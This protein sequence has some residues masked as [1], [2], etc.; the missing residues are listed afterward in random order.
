MA[1]VSSFAPRALCSSLGSRWMSPRSCGEFR[2]EGRGAG[3]EWGGDGVGM[4]FCLVLVRFWLVGGFS[5]RFLVIFWGV[6]RFW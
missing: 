5:Q 3:G 1:A 2:A 4:C 6:F